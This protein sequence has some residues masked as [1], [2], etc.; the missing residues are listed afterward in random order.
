M[1]YK[2]LENMWQEPFL[3]CL[4]MCR[5]P[6]DS[7]PVYYFFECIRTCVCF[8]F[9]IVNIW[10]SSLAGEIT[11]KGWVWGNKTEKEWVGFMEDWR[12][13]CKAKGT[14]GGKRSLVEDGPGNWGHQCFCRVWEAASRGGF[15]RRDHT[16]WFWHVCCRRWWTIY[17]TYFVDLEKYGT[18]ER[19]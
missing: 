18:E 11:V 14:V 2:S 3:I 12:G 9:G 6:Q 5:M 17:V 8:Y 15:A 16:V 13:G 4:S 1:L 7:F 10:N 19:V